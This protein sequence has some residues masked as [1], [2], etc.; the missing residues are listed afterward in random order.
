MRKKVGIILAALFYY[1]GLIR[2]ARKRF[3]RNNQSLI[4]LNYH[5]AAGGD[6]RRHLL[7]LHRHYRIMHLEEA[8]KELF[9]TGFD[10]R[11]NQDRRTKLTLTFDDGYHDNFTHAFK[12]AC[13]LQI[14]ITNFLIPGYIESGKPFR[15][16]E[17][18]RLA[19]LTLEK[20]YFWFR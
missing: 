8:L 9:D 7:Y 13:E 1:S 16:L 6:L 4:V 3:Q 5:R 17:G 18:K 2:F 20:F 11:N 15:W 12:L 14:P 10:H 19:N